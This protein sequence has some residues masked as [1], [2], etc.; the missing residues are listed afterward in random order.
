VITETSIHLYP[1]QEAQAPGK[2]EVEGKGQGIQGPPLHTTKA[3]VVEEEDNSR[4]LK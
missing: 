1:H 3:E 2:E 4:I